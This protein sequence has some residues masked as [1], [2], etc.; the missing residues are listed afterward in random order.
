MKTLGERERKL[1][2]RYQD[3][4]CGNCRYYREIVNDASSPHSECLLLGRTLGIST[5]EH[6][7]GRWAYQRLCDGWK[8]MPKSWGYWAH[9]V[10]TNPYFSDPHISRKTLERLR[11]R[12]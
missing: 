9:R 12:I 10:K 11:A 7:L 4:H 6:D 5:D 1:R 2:L 3:R 8:M